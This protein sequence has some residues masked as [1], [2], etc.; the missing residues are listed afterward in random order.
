VIDLHSHILPGLDDGVRSSEDALE[1]ARLAVAEGVEA[2]AATP[3]VRADY[4]TTPDEMED[5][6][7]ALTAELE[8]NDIP[9]RVLHGG[10]I[11]VGLLWQLTKQDLLRF[12]I[13]QTG[14]YLLLEVPY[15]GA[16]AAL[17][18]AVVRLQN[19][20]ITP[21]LAHPERNPVVQDRPDLLEPLTNAGA[22]IQVTAASV[23]GQLDRSSQLAAEKLLARG[24][25]HVL[26]TDT[27]GSHLARGGLADAVEAI[28]DPEVAEYLTSRVPE[29]IAKG[30]DLPPLR[31]RE[32]AAG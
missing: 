27:H 29:A 31:E 10:E 15:R 7:A 28:A 1:V 14:R 11:D 24:A 21:I 20:G 25:V 23:T 16:P 22:L 26:A 6:V 2:I 9:L 19:E 18:G 32:P 4:P 17:L 3:H 8:E 30:L 5:G 12:T 13:G